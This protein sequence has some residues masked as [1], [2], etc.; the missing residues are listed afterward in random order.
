MLAI[1]LAVL[2]SLVSP[3]LI[4]MWK[5]RYDANPEPWET[6]AADV[7]A[8][9]LGS[10]ILAVIYFVELFFRTLIGPQ[11][12]GFERFGLNV[13]RIPLEVYPGLFA[14]ACI[15]AGVSA[16]WKRANSPHSS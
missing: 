2:T 8:I 7:G 13:L 6:L 10:G 11:T 15:G 4:L 14:F 9:V 1:V 16:I 12:N 5:R 3:V